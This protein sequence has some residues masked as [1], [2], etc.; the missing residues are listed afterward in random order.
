MN[1]AKIAASGVAVAL[2][3]AELFRPTTVPQKR[4]SHPHAALGAA[5]VAL[6]QEQID[7]LPPI[8]A[9]AVGNI[10]G[11]A[12]T[13]HGVP[14]PLR[15]PLRIGEAE[16]LV[17][18]GWCADPETHAAGVG[19]IAIVD[20]TRRIDV[21]DA[22]GGERADVAKLF[23]TAAAPVEFIVPLRGSRIGRGEHGLR[24]AVIA[25]D[26]RG[27]FIFPTVVHVFVSP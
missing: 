24:V 10:D 7:D 8:V 15:Q 17:I 9:P 14:Q 1:A 12:A 26:A 5:R 13:L 21:S 19:L 2:L 23:G 20:D 6:T 27:I 3:A 18:S 4:L 16:T 22:Y 11:A 25:P